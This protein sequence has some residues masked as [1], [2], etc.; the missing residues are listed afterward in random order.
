MAINICQMKENPLR[1]KQTSLYQFKSVFYE[2]HSILSAHEGLNQK[3]SSDRQLSGRA[4][5]APAF[6]AHAREREAAEGRGDAISRGQAEQRRA[7][8]LL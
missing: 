7:R 8:S 6:I 4:N 1:F 3:E 5:T 2:K